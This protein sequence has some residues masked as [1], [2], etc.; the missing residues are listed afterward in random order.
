MVETPIGHI[1][2][3]RELKAE[4]ILTHKKHASVE[5]LAS[6]AMKSTSTIYKACSITEDNPPPFDA[7][8]IVPFT[9][10]KRNYKIIRYLNI[11]TGHLPPVKLPHFARS[12]KKF[13]VTVN[14]Y[15]HKKLS[16]QSEL[17]D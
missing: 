11:M 4:L 2:K 7:D 1:E 14:H 10:A 15:G 16:G 13:A 17:F 12:E 9:N 8:W 3:M 6:L 5:D